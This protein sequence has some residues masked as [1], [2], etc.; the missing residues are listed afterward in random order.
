MPCLDIVVAS[1]YLP[2]TLS[3]IIMSEICSG[4]ATAVSSKIFGNFHNLGMEN[5]QHAPLCCNLSLWLNLMMKFSS[6]EIYAYFGH[7]GVW[8]NEKF[9]ST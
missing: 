7:L 1:Y 8:C 4:S 9:P 2:Y 6:L 5:M 3:T